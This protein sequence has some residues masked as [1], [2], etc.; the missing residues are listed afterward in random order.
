MPVKIWI[1]LC[2]YTITLFV[3]L[4]L[5]KRSANW[6]IRLL[7]AALG[8]MLISQSVTLMNLRDLWKLL[9]AADAVIS[10]Q[11]LIA[12]LALTAVHLLN[13]ENRD[14]RATDNR[15]RIIE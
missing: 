3:V 14:R 8:L 13:R 6:R 15:L 1:V 2:A 11:L 10:M 12:V 7:C 4:L 5:I 9:P